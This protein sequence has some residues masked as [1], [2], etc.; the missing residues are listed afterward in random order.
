M[1][2]FS[3]LNQIKDLKEQAKNLQSQLAQESVTAEKCG[4]TLVMDGN[5]KITKLDISEE[6]LAPEKKEQLENLLIDLHDEA[7]KKVQRLMA[8]KMK[9]SGG[10]N[11]PGMS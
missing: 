7:I 10:F 4:V 2:L 9:A 3:K 6:Y 1:S 11:L 5:Q 8:E